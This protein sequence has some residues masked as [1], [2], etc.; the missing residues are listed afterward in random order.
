[1]SM[2]GERASESSVQLLHRFAFD[3]KN[4]FICTVRPVRQ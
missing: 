2:L 4:W 1:M 3:Q